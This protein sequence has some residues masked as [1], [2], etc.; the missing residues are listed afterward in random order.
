MSF[1][2]TF[3]YTSYKDVRT[4]ILW[5][6]VVVLFALRFVVS[7]WV[8]PTS[9]RDFIA[10][11][12]K[13]FGDVTAIGSFAGFT[14][15]AVII[16]VAAFVLSEL[17]R[18][19]DH[20]YDKHIVRWRHE[21]DALYILQRLVE[22]FASNMPAGR[23]VREAE[24]NKSTFMEQLYYPFVGDEHMKISKNKV[25]RFYEM[26]TI[27]WLTQV[28]EIVAIALLTL[29]GYYSLTHF[30]HVDHGYAIRLLRTGL[31]VGLIIGINRWFMYSA[32]RSVKKRTDEEIAAIH[33][34]RKLE[35]E[36]E[37]LL[38]KTCKDYSIP[39]K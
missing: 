25:L 35:S 22:P 21:F 11:L 30:V 19:H 9:H 33:S 3:N 31:V 5:W 17:L 38:K 13:D 24:R 10:K 16:L 2:P 32:R 26:V 15:G 1:L 20:W 23:F 18:V 28:N 7:Q 14:V 36:L 39:Y 12:V 29:V 27:Y 4:N 37:E 8:L 34:D 6:W